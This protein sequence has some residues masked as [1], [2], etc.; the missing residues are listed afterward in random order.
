MFSRV[1]MEHCAKE[2]PMNTAGERKFHAPAGD[3]AKA[4]PFAPVEE[5][6]R[7]SSKLAETLAGFHKPTT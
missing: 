1:V 2:L 4:M 3:G 7:A 6:L 5:F